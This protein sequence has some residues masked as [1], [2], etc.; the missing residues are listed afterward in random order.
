M[1]RQPD[2]LLT[3]NA[4]HISCYRSTSLCATLQSSYIHVAHHFL[5]EKH[6]LTEVVHL[7]YFKFKEFIQLQLIQ[8][9]QC[10]SSIIGD[11]GLCSRSSQSRIIIE[12]SK[13]SR[14]WGTQK[15]KPFVAE[16]TGAPICFAPQF[17]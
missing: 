15:I 16:S 17:A 1:I 6:S 4:D 3:F 13:F 7:L 14:F 2:N 9:V 8:S 10:A 12:Y 11:I 5:F